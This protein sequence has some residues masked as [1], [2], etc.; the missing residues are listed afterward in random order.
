MADK[1]ECEICKNAIRQKYKHFLVWQIL[2]II[3]MCLT[4]LFATLYFSSGEVFTQTNNENETDIEVLNEGANN[5]NNVVV[6]Y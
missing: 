4:I 3:F 2:A 5:Y 1:K 6:D